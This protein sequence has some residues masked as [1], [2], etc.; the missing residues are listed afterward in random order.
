MIGYFSVFR[1]P[2]KNAARYPLP[3]ARKSSTQE[4]QAFSG[5]GAREAGGD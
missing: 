2:E 3:V 5:N 1:C 4:V